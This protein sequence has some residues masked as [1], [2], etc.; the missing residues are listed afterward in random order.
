M[1]IIHPKTE[2][3]KKIEH[4]TQFHTEEIVSLDFKNNLVL[5]GGV[6]GLMCLSNWETAN[7][8]IRS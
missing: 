1:R 6:E 7:V 4:G 5:S 3:V 2:E 8:L